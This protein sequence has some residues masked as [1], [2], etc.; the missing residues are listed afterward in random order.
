MFLYEVNLTLDNKTRESFMAW[1]PGHIKRVLRAEGF[2]K[3]QVYEEETLPHKVTVFYQI[4]SKKALDFYFQG[5]GKEMRK[6]ALEK[7][8]GQFEA[9]RKVHSFIKEFTGE[10]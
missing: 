1:L 3:A 8:S 4:E 7:F 9:S 10:D 6:E 2:K 5:Y